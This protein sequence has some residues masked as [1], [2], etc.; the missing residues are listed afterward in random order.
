VSGLFSADEV[1]ARRVR[2]DD[3]LKQMG[4]S[5]PSETVEAFHRYAEQQFADRAT[6]AM[7]IF[8]DYE[9]KNSAEARADLERRTLIRATADPS[10]EFLGH[11][12]DLLQEEAAL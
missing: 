10:K 6:R 3:W 11:L 9:A 7:A 5:F 4:Y 12:E 2:R 8:K 1:A